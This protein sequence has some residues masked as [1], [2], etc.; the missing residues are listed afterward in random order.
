MFIRLL[1][2]IATMTNGVQRCVSISPNEKTLSFRRISTFALDQPRAHS[3]STI[4]PIGGNWCGS[5]SVLALITA[6]MTLGRVSPINF[7]RIS[8][9]GFDRLMVTPAL[10]PSSCKSKAANS[11]PLPRLPSA[12]IA[13]KSASASLW[14][15][16]GNHRTARP[17]VSRGS[18]GF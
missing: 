12:S 18:P 1:L 8:I 4:M 15:L 11:D 9:E 5:D 7:A 13:N 17:Q 6:L 2:A 10:S 14:A 16:A 3:A